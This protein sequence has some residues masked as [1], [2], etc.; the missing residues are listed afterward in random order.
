LPFFCKRLFFIL[1]TCCA[2]EGIASAQ[3]TGSGDFH[4]SLSAAFV[5]EVKAG[6]NS[7]AYSPLLNDA[8]G[9]SI[10]Y[11]FQPRRWLALEAGFEQIIHPVGSS[12]CCEYTTNAND[13]LYLVPFGARYVWAPGNSRL[14]LS[15]GGGGAYLNH[16][17]GNQ[18]GGIAGFNGW[19]GQV[20]A[21]VDYAVT[22][23]GRLRAGL[24]ARYYFASPKPSPNFAGPGFPQPH[25]T[26]HVFVLGPEVTF[27]FR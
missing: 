2:A 5:Y 16:T 10:N 19:G 4:Q 14:R 20:V 26:V 23:S 22:R 3:T 18:A 25:D 27:S 15:G 17:I 7:G 24:T 9:Y 1:F 12:V 11:W 6:P 13:Q 8:P 21:A